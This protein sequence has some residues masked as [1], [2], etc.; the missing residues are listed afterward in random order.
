MCFVVRF[1]KFIPK[2][3]TVNE[4]S[5]TLVSSDRDY[6]I[7]N[8]TSQR[9]HCVMIP[10]FD[11]NG[12]LPPGVHCASWKE[13]THRFGYNPWRTL[14]L[15][16]LRAALENL[17]SSGCPMAYIDGSFVTDKERPKDFDA[18]WEENGVNPLALDP[19]LLTFDPGRATQKRK[20]LGEMFPAGAIADGDGR[21]YLEFFQIDMDTNSPKGIIAIDLGKLT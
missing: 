10:E 2:M 5:A 20:Y 8:E 11:D 3:H 19:V 14:L 13:F 6:L 21:T 15:I 18:C 12:L 17:K 4:W 9:Y 1:R 16:G 7:D